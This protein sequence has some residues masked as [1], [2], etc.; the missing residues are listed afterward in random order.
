[1][2]LNAEVSLKGKAFSKDKK[3]LTKARFVCI[4]T[5]ALLIQ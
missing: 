3:A 2:T 1:M 5:L 4:I